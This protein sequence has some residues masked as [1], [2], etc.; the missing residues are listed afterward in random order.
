M[1]TPATIRKHPVHPMLVTLPIGLLIFS[2]ISDIIFLAGWGP[3]IWND[4][5]FYTLGGGII[6]ALLAAIP[7]LIDFT[8]LPAGKIRST[9]TRHLILNLLMV[10]IFVIDFALRWNRPINLTI[11]FV[12]SVLGVAI[13]FYSGWLGANLVH[14]H[15]VTI[16]DEHKEES[17]AAVDYR[18]AD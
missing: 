1:Q 7:G 17:P 2:P 3:P 11:P 15:R 12:L 16:S 9:A 14:E 4:V 18:K 13:L 10:A 6:A 8:S 5:A